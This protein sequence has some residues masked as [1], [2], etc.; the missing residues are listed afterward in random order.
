MN[1]I[2][3]YSRFFSSEP[4]AAGC[5]LS[6]QSSASLR[7]K[8]KPPPSGHRYAS[9]LGCDG[10]SRKVIRVLIAA[11]MSYSCCCFPRVASS[12]RRILAGVLLPTGGIHDEKH[13]V[14]Y[15][16]LCNVREK[17]T[18][19]FHCASDT[20]RKPQS[21]CCNYIQLDSIL[22]STGICVYVRYGGV[23]AEIC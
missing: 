16:L 14:H 6:K 1:E 2:F 17:V 13:M 18:L 20:K 8:P 21:R 9:G 4:V 10:S 22:L 15:R 23:N 19:K 11:V 5:C 12:L 3:P 7:I